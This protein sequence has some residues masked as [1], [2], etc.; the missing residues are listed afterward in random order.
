MWAEAVQMLNARWREVKRGRGRRA[1]RHAMHVTAA[2]ASDSSQAGAVMTQAKRSYPDL[3]SF[4]AN[5]DF[6]RQAQRAAHAL[7]CE[8][9]VTGKPKKAS[10]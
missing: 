8:L 10:P 9:Q 6:R 2:N 3:E 1:P 7:D 4:T 5:Q